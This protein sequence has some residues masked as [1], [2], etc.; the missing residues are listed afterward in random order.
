MVVVV[1]QLDIE[2]S[3]ACRVA[4]EQYGGATVE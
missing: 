2:I 1:E 4:H 3:A